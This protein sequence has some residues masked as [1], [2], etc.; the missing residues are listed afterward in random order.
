MMMMMMMT[1]LK[2]K[3]VEQRLLVFNGEDVKQ[4]G[5]LENIGIDVQENTKMCVK[6]RL[7]RRRLA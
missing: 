5:S 4:S 3:G 6:N 7:G 1:K 2:R